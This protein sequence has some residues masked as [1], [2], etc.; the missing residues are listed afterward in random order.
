MSEAAKLPGVTSKKQG[1]AWVQNAK[2]CQLDTIAYCGCGQIQGVKGPLTECQHPGTDGMQ[3]DIRWILTLEA[4]EAAVEAMP[5]DPVRPK[6]DTGIMEAAKRAAAG[7]GEALVRTIS[8]TGADTLGHIIQCIR[9]TTAAGDILA[10][11]QAARIVSR[12]K[13]GA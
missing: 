2:S 4:F 12:L 9:E 6:R 3:H 11:A 13:V 10:L 8:K 7:E 5:E 1:R